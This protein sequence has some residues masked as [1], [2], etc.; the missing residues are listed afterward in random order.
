MEIF[1]SE[2]VETVMMMTRVQTKLRAIK[3]SLSDRQT[4]GPPI[5]H[6]VCHDLKSWSASWDGAEYSFI[7]PAR[8]TTR[9]LPET[10]EPAVHG[11]FAPLCSFPVPERGMVKIPNARM[12]GQ[13]GLV[14]LPNGEFVG[15]LVALTTDGRQ[16]ML[17]A[18]RSYYEPLPTKPIHKKGNF[19][20]VL[21]LGVTNYYHFSH[22]IIMRLLGIA[23]R[24]PPDTQFLVPKRMT[25]FQLETLALVGLDGRPQVPFPT[26]ESWEL[27]NLYVVTP[28]SKTQIDSPE[29]LSRYR[30]VAMERHGIRESEPTKRLFVTRRDDRHWRATNEE[31]V[32]SYLST[33]GFE[34]VSPVKM[35]FCEQI[36]IFSQAAVIV[37]T[38]AGMTNMVFCP[39]GAKVL[40]FQ[41]PRHVIH[42]FWTMAA[43]LGFDYHYFF[44][45]VIENPGQATVDI[46]VPLEKLEASLAR[47]M[48]S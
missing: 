4:A 7:E 17:R 20:P 15:E 37:G 46:H 1:T 32:E 27:E 48:G 13:V 36:E 9:P 40:Q 41:E 35:S 28:V 6:P 31:E 21:G 16:S 38:G 10:I 30:K 12:R 43:A 29:P 22:D 24:L 23:D 45:D 19:Y 25:T 11:S 34:T 42:S 39:P 18:E 47:M 33:C 3:R 44:C 26:D 8:T 5:D 14:I 2:R